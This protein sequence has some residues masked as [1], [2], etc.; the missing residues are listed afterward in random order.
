[1]VAAVPRPRQRIPSVLKEALLGRLFAA[2]LVLL[3]AGAI[4][5]SVLVAKQQNEP[6][7]ASRYNL[8]WLVSQAGVE[9]SR[10]QTA[11]A[12]TA[13]SD[14][15]EATD[16]QLQFDILLNRAKTLDTGD[17][18]EFFRSDPELAAIVQQLAQTLD[19]RSP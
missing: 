5:T 4:Y 13:L 6:S 11:V 9:L 3:T 16:V 17:A 18:Q 15:V 10:L 12:A 1:M 19:R 2:V 7:G 8:T 14:A